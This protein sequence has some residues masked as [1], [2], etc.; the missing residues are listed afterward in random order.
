MVRARSLAWELLRAMG[1]AKKKKGRKEIFPYWEIM[2]TFSC[3]ML[4]ALLDLDQVAPGN[5]DVK[6]IKKGYGS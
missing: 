3:Y 5:P 2:N 1:V 4:E 6:P